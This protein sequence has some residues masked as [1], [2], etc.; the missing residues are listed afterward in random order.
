MICGLVQYLTWSGEKI[1]TTGPFKS[2]QRGWLAVYLLAMSKKIIFYFFWFLIQNVV[3]IVFLYIYFQNFFKIS[4]LLLKSLIF[5]SFIQLPIGYKVRTSMH[6]TNITA[7]IKNKLR[8]Y[9]LPDLVQACYL[10][11]LL[12]VWLINSNFHI[13]NKFDLKIN[14]F[15]FE[16]CF[17]CS[18][19]KRMSVAYGC[20]YGLSCIT[21]LYNSYPLL[22]FGRV[23][24]G[25]IFLKNYKIL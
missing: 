7:L 19:R 9:S 12:A 8:I 16:F 6:C 21:K 25:N 17:F 3:E 5:S 15:L 2:F 10:A 22:L 14:C 1:T 4:L 23:L 24:A 20:F 11:R 13:K 18:G